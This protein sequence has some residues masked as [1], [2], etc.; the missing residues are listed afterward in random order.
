MSSNAV[1]KNTSSSRGKEARL[2]FFVIEG[3]MMTE[4]KSFYKTVG[5]NEGSK[6]RYSTRLAT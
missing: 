2:L 5:G 3:E 6:C 1:T 4:Y